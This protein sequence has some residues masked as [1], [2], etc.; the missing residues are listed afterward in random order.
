MFLQGNAIIFHTKM[1]L[2]N[3]WIYLNRRLTLNNNCAFKTREEKLYIT[4]IYN[5][6]MMVLVTGKKAVV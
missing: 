2:V 6:Y 4:V 1:W 3:K 5:N